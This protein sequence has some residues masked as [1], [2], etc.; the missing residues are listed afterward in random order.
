MKDGCLHY[1][2]KGYEMNIEKSYKLY[3][4]LIF[5]LL[6]I[7]CGDS[8]LEL[9]IDS[10]VDINE[11]VVSTINTRGYNGVFVSAGRVQGLKYMCG[12]KLAYTNNEGVFNCET[13]PVRF[14]IGNIYLGGIENL[15]DTYTVFPQSLLG[16]L[17]AATKH[18]DVT[19]L[20]SFLQ[21]L[22]ED[23]NSGN[24]ILIKENTHKLINQ[25][26][27][28]PKAYLKLSDE[29]LDEITKLVNINMLSSYS[30]SDIQD[31][32]TIAITKSYFPKQP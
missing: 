20:A 9:P 5:S 25:I 28:N 1:S 24:G 31:D 18:P 12:E 7:G 3:T 6:F 21:S 19:K 26:V 8:S 4:I 15:D 13:Y 10:K 30:E 29:E 27:T 2:Y 11:S 23:G 22:D 16:F 32:L 14:Y 17:V